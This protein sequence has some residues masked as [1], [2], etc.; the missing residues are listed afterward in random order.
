MAA[1][2]GG[3]VR[4]KSG[5]PEALQDFPLGWRSFSPALHALLIVSFSSMAVDMD[6]YKVCSLAWGQQA[7]PEL[8][9]QPSHPV[10]FHPIPSYP[11]PS[12]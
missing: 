7:L 10:T 2:W 1:D 9:G 8:W 5:L 11:V 12:H 4:G 6:M 3:G